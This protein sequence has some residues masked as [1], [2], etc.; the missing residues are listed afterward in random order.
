M[1]LHRL[2]ALLLVLCAAACQSATD[3]VLP[4]SR[5]IVGASRIEA[6]EIQ[7]RPT[8]A[9][10]VGALDE[11]ARTGGGEG[12]AALPFAQMLDAAVRDA[13]TRA[14]L[15][16]ARPLKL[17]LEIDEV[18]VPGTGAA[19][20]GAQDRLAGTVFVR[21]AV[22]GAALGQLYVDVRAS[23]AGLLGLALRGGGVRER[24]AAAFADRIAGALSGGNPR[25]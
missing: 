23:N 4:L 24:L 17:L 1:P 22:S 19:L 3:V 20:F 15:S 16:G 18:A 5:S 11:R 10:A 2:S 14:G 8:A 25:R 6:V 13:A 21:D 9:P 12:A 7:V